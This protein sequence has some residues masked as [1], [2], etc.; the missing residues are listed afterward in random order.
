MKKLTKIQLVNWHFFSFQIIDIESNTLVSGENGSGKSTLLDALQYVL[1]GERNHVKFNIAANVNAKRSLESYM[2]CKIGAE[3][4]EFL[5]DQDV[6]THILL[7]FYDN[8]N[9][10]YSIFGCVL[11][12]SR[13]SNL[14][15]KFYFIENIQFINGM[16]VEDNQPKTQKQLLLFLRQYVPNFNFFDTKKQYQNAISNYLNINMTKYIQM[17]P[18]ALAFKPLNLQNFVFEFLLEPNPVNI[19]SLKN[20]FKQLKKLELQIEFE[21]NKL[22]HLTNIIDADKKFIHLKDQ[23]QIYQC[24]LY[25]IQIKK[26]HFYFNYYQSK[27]EA[28]EL[29]LKKLLF[30]KEKIN[31]TIEN[32]NNEL[33]VLKSNDKNLFLNNLQKDLVFYQNIEKNLNNK[34]NLFQSQ[35]NQELTNLKQLQDLFL[36]EIDKDSINFISNFLNLEFSET[37]LSLP[38]LKIILE[39]LSVFISKEIINFNIQKNDFNKIILDLQKKISEKEND[40]RVLS[41]VRSVYPRHIQK[42]IEILNEKLSDFYNLSVFIYP[43]C[44]LIDINDNLWRNAIEGFLGNR[45]FNLLIEENYF[46][47]A[48]KIYRNL[49][50]SLDNNFY[51]I[52][53]VNVAQI[54]LIKDNANSLSTKIS[55]SNQNALK[56]IRLLLS[57]IICELDSLNLKK[58]KTAITPDCLVYSQYTLRKINPKLYQFP[59]IGNNSIKMRENLFL[60]EIQKSKSLIFKHKSELSK[61]QEILNLLNKS[62]LANILSSD[63]FNLYSEL[64]SIKDKIKKIYKQI[65]ELKSDLRFQC[66]EDNLVSLME[67]KKNNNE[68]LEQILFKMAEL[69]NNL[70]HYESENIKVRVTL[71]ELNQKLDIFKNKINSPAI[72]DKINIHLYNYCQKYNDNYELILSKVNDYLKNIEQQK[73]T[74]QIELINKMQ[75]YLKTYNISHIEAK[76]ENL[77]YFYQ[78]YH[79]INSQNLSSYEQEAKELTHKT[80]I[81]FKEEFINKLKESIDNTKQQIHKLNKLLN[82]RPFGNDSYQILIKPSNDPDY[83]KYYDVISSYENNESQNELLERGLMCENTLL[84]ELFDKIISFEEGYEDIAES[85]LDYRNYMTYDIQIKDINNNYSLFSKI[86]REKSGGETQVPFYIIMSICFEQLITSSQN[87]QG[88]LVLFDEAFNN[89]D[90]A[91]IEGMMCFFNSL[92]IQFIMAIP[93]QR[94]VD[95]SPYVQTNLIIIKDNNHVVVEN[96]TRNVLNF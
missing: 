13:S 65:N 6:I 25:Q 88:C 52:G 4:K 11:E 73:L 66:V 26:N 16:C 57:N 27:K 86:F 48:L 29:S 72:E 83:K 14:K 59:Y 91:R 56:Y 43:L 58:H 18:K 53:L 76:L 55:S 9:K 38:R 15:E 79:S 54:P 82:D 17:L 21:K 84:E 47:Q 96:F 68:Q 30:K 74:Q 92:K 7:E 2:R 63:N 8:V 70:H 36:F 62:Q 78:E 64:F 10:K 60:S 40:C 1:I 80:E 44:E 77:E 24:L 23:I 90:E 93:P 33:A 37:K 22:F 95:I 19:S 61:Y 85:F 51:D 46:D 32:L 28:D 42:L 75:L 39:K 69:K 35:I 5:R 50:Q 20:S 45:K 89:M 71:S 67:Q 49:P 3:N 34:I 81:I 87:N 12:L 31:L 94:I 41:S